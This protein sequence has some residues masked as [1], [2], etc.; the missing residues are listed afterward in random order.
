MEESLNCY[1]CGNEYTIYYS[2]RDECEV[3][4]GSCKCSLQ[5]QK[6]KVLDRAL[7][8]LREVTNEKHQSITNQVPRKS[9]TN[10]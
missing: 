8:K 7:L 3:V 1:I 2:Y 6:T 4:Y 9:K 5:V 10:R